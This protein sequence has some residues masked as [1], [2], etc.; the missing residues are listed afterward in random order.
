[1]KK[2]KKYIFGWD[3]GGTKVSVVL[4]DGRR[5]FSKRVFPSGR[6]LSRKTL[7]RQLVYCSRLLSRKHG[8][9]RRQIRGIGISCPGPLDPV[10]GFIYHSP[11][12]PQ[13]SRFDLAKSVRTK[14]QLPVKVENDANCAAL[15]EALKG[16]GKGHSSLFYVTVSTGIGGGFV[17][18]GN[19]I[20]GKNFGAGELG[21]VVLDPT[22]PRCFC[23]KRGCLEALA[24]GTAMTRLAREAVQKGRSRMMK[25][26][27]KGDIQL[28]DAFTVE[29]AARRGDPAAKKIWKDAIQWLGLGL[30]GVIQIVNP[31]VIAVGG[32][33]SQAGSFLMN[34]LTQAIRKTTWPDSFRATKIVRAKLGDRVADWGAVSLWM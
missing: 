3:L 25:K 24:S 1:M 21:H 2:K 14:M 9:L 30:S 13:L 8:V 27:C 26:L 28:I 11:N 29:K 7:L 20:R 33:V 34:P 31:S 16:S 4:S 15:C 17:A 5:I 18:D 32:G 6:S 12:L 23:G 19:L 22:G 10:R